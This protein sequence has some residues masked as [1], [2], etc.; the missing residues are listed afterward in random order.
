MNVW[1]IILGHCLEFLAAAAGLLLG[2]SFTKGQRDRFPVLK[3]LDGKQLHLG[4]LVIIFVAL[5]LGINA[6]KGDYS[7]DTAQGTQSPARNP[8]VNA[9]K[10]GSS[11]ETVLISGGETFEK[12]TE[13]GFQ[14]ELREAAEGQK[15]EANSHFNAGEKDFAASKFQSAARNYKASIE[16]LPTMAACL[17]SGKSF[18]YISD[19]PGAE[20]AYRQGLGI[21]RQK[22]EQQFEAAFLAG[23][24]NVYADK[25]KLEDALNYLQQALA[26]NKSIGY[27]LGEADDLSYIAVVYENKGNLDEAVNYHQQALAIDKSIGNHLGEAQDFGSIGNVY[28]IKGKLDDAQKYYQQSLITYKSIGNPLGE[29]NALGSIGNVYYLKGNL[30]EALNY[31]QQALPLHKSIG[32]S[33]GV[34]SDLFNIGLLYFTK[35]KL[36]D[37]LNSFQQAHTLY[38][39]IGANRQ[40]QKLEAIIIMIKLIG[41]AAKQ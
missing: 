34:A 3:K 26:L 25:G 12:A 16:C 14:R 38:K 6:F 10:D 32:N 18:Y 19:Y 13:S 36:D 23:I 39:T 35:G 33:L 40:L 27:S 7:G 24:G 22:R 9:F 37:A 2:L 1:L 20:E 31:H 41:G 8:R 11:L 28:A 21:A 15:T 4:L 17:N 5:S 30:D 29:A